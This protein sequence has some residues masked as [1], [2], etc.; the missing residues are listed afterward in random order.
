MSND[1]ANQAVLRCLKN[2]C[3][4]ESSS[5][6]LS[7]ALL[8]TLAECRSYAPYLTELAVLWKLTADRHGCTGRGGARQSA[9]PRAEHYLP[10]AGPLTSWRPI[11]TH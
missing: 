1:G 4:L 2:L 6:L 8:L 10:V 3:V 7:D 11:D 9:P 5:M